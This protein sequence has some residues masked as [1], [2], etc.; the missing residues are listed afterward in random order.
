[1]DKNILENSTFLLIEQEY[2]NE[3][4]SSREWVL[5]MHSAH[6][7]ILKSLENQGLPTSGTGHVSETQQITYSYS[8]TCYTF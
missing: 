1:M 2:Q 6:Q 3:Q 7:Q 5:S 4:N 8:H